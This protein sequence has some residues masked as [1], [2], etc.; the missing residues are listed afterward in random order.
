MSRK[1]RALLSLATGFGTG[2][3]GAQRQTKMDQEREED[4]SM[5]RAEHDARMGEVQEQ[6]NLR[7]S[8]ADAARPATV[9]EGAGGAIRPASMDDRDVG[10]AD[11][12]GMPNGGLSLASYRVKDKAFD[13]KPAAEAEVAAYNAPDARRARQVEALDA[14]G[15]PAEAMTLA[16]ATAVQ[17]QN[18]AKFTQEQLAQAQKMKSEGFIEAAKAS[19]TGDPQ[20]VF[21]A[22]NRSGAMKL[23]EPPTVT[24]AERDLP[25][26]GKVQTFDYVARVLGP[27][28]APR[29]VKVNSHDLSMQTLPFEKMLEFGLKGQ[30]ADMKAQKTLA[31]M[32]NATERLRLT[33]EVNAAKA[34]AAAAKAT[35]AAEG[36]PL[37]ISAANGLLSNQQ[38]LRRAQ[39]ALAM[40]NG[41]TVDGAVGDPNATGKKG[42]IPNQVLNRMDPAGVE[43]R[44]AIADLGS[45]VIH[46]RSGA[47]VTASE[48]PRLA[49]FIP[50]EKDDAATVKKKLALFTK[51]YQ[52]VVDDASEFYKS[53]G[54]RVPT[55]VLKSVK[56]SSSASK[57]ANLPDNVPRVSSP[58]DAMKLAPGTVFIDSNGVTRRRP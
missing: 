31:D 36:K 49:P 33:G 50:T 1:S 44:A 37:P 15:K 16:N 32:G 42:W 38:N 2:Y 57:T 55:E 17:R 6:K 10:G 4:R 35:K 12:Q 30:G 41:E 7:V 47:A 11:T 48:F 22:F 14:A 40:V 13:T 25:G 27:D 9:E 24:P 26:I 34:E 20:A 28:G 8:L 52:A 5:R 54:Y 43:T 53:S 46:D 58:A 23:V 56:G 21:E 29:E 3:L 18:Q 51:N 39:Q 19:R 45:L